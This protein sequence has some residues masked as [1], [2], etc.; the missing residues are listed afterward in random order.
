MELFPKDRRLCYTCGAPKLQGQLE[1]RCR[2]CE[3]VVERV[4]G[5]MGMCDVCYVA[6]CREEIYEDERG[7][8]S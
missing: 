6:E 1:M 2:G 7:W 3:T 4:D 8:V 5:I